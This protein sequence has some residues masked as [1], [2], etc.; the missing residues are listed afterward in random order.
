MSQKNRKTVTIRCDE[1][2]WERVEPLL[3]DTLADVGLPVER[4]ELICRSVEETLRSLARYSDYKGLEH[5]L[6][7]SIEVGGGRFKV[8]LAD[9]LTDF[10]WTGLMA[11]DL[12]ASEKP[13]R[14]GVETAQAVM[15]EISYTYKKGARSE[16]ELVHSI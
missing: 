1:R 10:A 4:K 14:M 2:S 12:A 7:V 16:L 6:A 9:S 11:E 3:R 13:W 5:D 15:D 8:V